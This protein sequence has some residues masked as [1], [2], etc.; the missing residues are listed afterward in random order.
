MII[1]ES[2]SNIVKAQRKDILLVNKGIEREKLK[3]IKVEESFAIIISGVRRCGKST[4]LRQMIQKSKNFYYFNFEDPSAVNFE[5]ADFET[6]NQV[7]NEEYGESNYYFFDE[8]QN[9]EK[10]ELFVRAMLDKGKYF[11]ITGSNAS[12]LSRELGT[13]LTGRHLNYELF[14]F[15][16]NEFLKLTGK[17]PNIE[18]FKEYFIKGGFPQYLRSRRIESIQDLFNDIINR[19]ISIRHKIRNLKS[20]KE[21]AVYLITNVGKEFSYNSLK[22]TFGLGS[23]NSAISFVSFFEDSYMLFTIPKF[24]YSIKKQIINPKKVYSIDNGFS[25]VN[26]ASFSEDKGKMLENITFLNLRKIYKEIFYFQEKGECDFVIKEGTKITRAIQVCYNL[27][28]QNKKRELNGLIEAL[29]KF[30][31]KEGLILTYNQED[32]FVIEDKIIKAI[33]VWKWLLKEK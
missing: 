33:P 31:L 26:S 10:W 9:V 12:L 7:F 6:L 8:V 32:K 19:D 20:L 15:S 27:T 24:D 25:V 13:R 22:K 28:E 29:D 3:E 5:L 1:K 17:K 2:L 4:L 16:F 23:V 18:S 14:P 21:M 11:V 30:K